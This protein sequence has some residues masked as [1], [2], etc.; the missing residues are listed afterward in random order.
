[1]E[2]RHALAHIDEL[3]RTLAWLRSLTPDGQRYKVWLGDLIEFTRAAF[4]LDSPQMGAIRAAIA[5]ENPLRSEA[6]EETRRLEYLARLDGLGALLSGFAE[7]L[8]NTPERPSNLIT[9]DD[10]LGPP[11]RNGRGGTR[12]GP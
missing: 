10:L 11:R 7:A 3:H 9:I 2:K 6:D 5:G 4:G 12:G 8:P 1:M